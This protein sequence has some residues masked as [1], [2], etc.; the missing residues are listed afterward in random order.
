MSHGT[1]GEPKSVGHE[2][3]GLF[4]GFGVEVEYMIVDRDTLD[5]RPV[6]DLLI[7]RVE[8]EPA[9]EI[10]RGELAWSNE[11]VLHVLELKTN[12]PAPALT[13][14]SALFQESV[15]DA[16]DRLAPLGAVLLP[17]GAHPWMD[18]AAET[19]LWPHEYND[20][21]RAFD[22]I[23][24]C[25]GHGWAN[26]Q[27]THLNLPF[28]GDREF[29]ALH[30]AI[31]ALLPLLPALAASSPFLDGRR[32]GALD[33]R[34]VEYRRN[35]TRIPAVAGLVVPD[36]VGTPDEY[37][38][39]ILEPIYRD[40]APHDPEGTLRHEWVNARGAIARF[41]RGTV[42]IRL[43]DVQE[44]PAADLAVVAATAR[45]VHALS[46][47]IL[48]GDHGPEGITTRE[49]ASILDAVIREADR[50]KVEP[51]RYREAV[52][53]R[54]A[55][56]RWARDLWWEILDGAVPVEW[57]AEAERDS[58]G[59]DPLRTILEKGCLARR[60]VEALEP[61]PGRAELAEVYGE[62]ADCLAA[63]RVFRA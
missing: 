50:A 14:L 18:P 56:S 44:C 27:A 13:R 61:E 59:N 53:L 7:E 42:E 62:L 28:R 16:N 43:L 31:R 54:R 45:A 6:A 49:L 35:S 39:E 52:G 40:L 12:G 41:E 63:G 19:R 22:R 9:A 36:A 58:D 20:V 2:S 51:A 3:L 57:V 48:D 25:R 30:S 17:G 11:L 10:E 1:G 47:R 55:G 15:T 38:L 26:L 23:F 21:Y 32:G 60:I 33:Q 46:E 37:R 4:E 29:R 8:G 5:V 34:L 24:S